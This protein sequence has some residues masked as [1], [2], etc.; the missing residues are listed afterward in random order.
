MARLHQL[1]GFLVMQA[2]ALLR[3]D[4]H[5]AFV[6]PGD[7]DH[8]TSLSDKQRQWLFNVN[9][10]AGGTGQHGHESMPM[11]GSGNDDRVH[12]TIVQEL[13]EVAVSLDRAADHGTGFFEPPAMYL[14]HRS[15]ADVRLGLKVEHMTVANQPV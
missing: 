12:V 1:F 13:S 6:S 7:V 14:S 4:L 3:P 8:P 2:G 9:V 10:L 15:H 5:H 11:V